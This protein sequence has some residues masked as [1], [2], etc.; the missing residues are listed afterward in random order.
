MT[1]A[2]NLGY[3]RIGPRR[4]L[5][6][7][8]EAYWAGRIDTDGL[9]REA[10]A[11]RRQA[12]ALQQGSGISH[13]PSGDFALYDHVLETA[14]AFGA[15]PAG[16]GWK[17]E[18]PVSLL[19]LFA[20]ARG[21]WGTAEEPRTGIDPAAQPLEMTK[22]FDTNYHYL[23][24]RLSS[25][26]R[27]AL[28]D[29]PWRRMFEEALRHG[30]R[31][32][33]VVLGPVSFLLLAKG[34]DGANPLAL[35]PALLPAYGQLL[36][37]LGDASAGWVQ[38]DEP[39]LATDLPAGAAEAYATAYHALAAAAPGLDLL[40]ATYFGGLRENLALSASL[41][42][43]GLHL[44][45][46]RDPGQLDV[47]LG[48]L[49]EEQWLSLG[50]VNGRNVWRTD[51]RAALALA[52]RATARPG[53]ARRLMLA[54]SCSLLHV[55]HSLREETALDP[56][57]RRRLAFADEKL[58]EVA[59]LARALDEGEAVAAAAL[60][61]SDAILAEQPPAATPP[62]IT[63]E[64]EQRPS[65]FPVRAA[66]QQ[67]KFRL[68][69]LPVTTIGSLPQTAEVRAARAEALRGNSDPAAY[70]AQ[71]RDLI[72][73]SI[74][75][76]DAI[77]VDVPVHGEFERN[78]MV[79]Y[80]AEQLE[81]Y[82]ITK[83][84][85]VQSYGSRCVSPPIL[86]G[87]VRRPKPMTVRW[88]SHAQSLTRRPVKGMLTGPVTMLQWA[89][90]RED[91]PRKAACRQI[92]LALR[93]EVA[94]LQA[95]GIGIIQIDEPAFR[96]GLPL[97]RSERADYLRWATACFRLTAGAAG[98][99]T[100]IH[101][102]M[103]YSEFEDILD[104]IAAMDADVIS[105]ETARSRMELLRAFTEFAYPNAIGPG[106][107]DIHSPRVPQVSEMVTLARSALACLPAERLWLNPDCGCKTRNWA[108]V[109]P[110]VV[111][112]VQAARTLRAELV[113]PL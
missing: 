25:E 111:N 26:M 89:F 21:A 74:A 23:V 2:A 24:P 103:C 46:V 81:G 52:R 65:P 60:T 80:F 97:R 86:W 92:A 56:S 18:G 35:L 40:L 32:R 36:R 8:L 99:A 75:W 67:A 91:I 113:P 88:S 58:A 7:A 72:A 12:W 33:P 20:L 85:W 101:T 3:P 17:G 30:C 4:E 49:R 62:I 64:M 110:A 66:V 11:L 47:A 14:C 106:V 107:W 6:R 105:I 43:A 44:D 1:I 96:E 10:A 55:P 59:L 28:H 109:R 5:K 22:W 102:H 108:E 42:V 29:N 39:C 69:P 19:T 38:M 112:L 50:L 82:A 70:E 53:G 84:G 13:V 37:E 54:P 34:E 73:D 61:A 98:D 68:P 95:A 76:Q 100:Q 63:P 31:T 79:K 27:F 15:I 77:G 87:D 83:H 78:D 71:M 51:L 104:A 16:Y 41:P 57:L 93:E 45:L 94:D 90:V 48:L 9:Q